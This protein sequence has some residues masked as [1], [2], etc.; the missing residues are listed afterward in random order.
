MKNFFNLLAVA[1][2]SFAGGSCLSRGMVWWGVIN[3]ILVF[4]N[5]CVVVAALIDS[6]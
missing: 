1:A 3:L 5:G 6:E 4:F 2:N